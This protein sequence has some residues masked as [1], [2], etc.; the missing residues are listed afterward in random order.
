[1]KLAP[2]YSLPD[3]TLFQRIRRFYL[4]DA[5]LSPTDDKV[6]IRWS[7]AFSILLDLKG[8]DRDCANA[9]IKQF[10]ISESQA[11]VD[12]ANAKRL[13]GDVRKSEKEAL[14]YMVTQWAIELYRMA[15]SKKDFRGMEKALERITKANNLDKE[16]QDIPDPSKVQPPI[17]LLQLSFN[18]VKSQYF[19]LIDQ[20]AQDEILR[21]VDKVQQIID[22][23]TVKDY[24]DLYQVSEIPPLLPADGNN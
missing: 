23:S 24:L 12:I 20:K 2:K 3:D 16:D 11:Y 18:F 14:R 5:E 9:M 19:H 21:V 1:M 6:R 13:F 10:K 4:S 8:S 22:K 7:A 15:Q 17:Q